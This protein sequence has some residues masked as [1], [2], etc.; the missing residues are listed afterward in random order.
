MKASKLFA[1]V[2]AAGLG[3]AVN[4]ANAQTTEEQPASETPATTEESTSTEGTTEAEPY[5]ETVTI[6]EGAASA[7]GGS[8]DGGGG[9]V[10]SERKERLRVYSGKHDGNNVIVD[11]R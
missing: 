11:P 8:T 4:Q 7:G 2:L 1:V 3:F 6:D 9:D 10:A 5:N